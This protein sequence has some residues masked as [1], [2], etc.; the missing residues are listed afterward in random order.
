[1]NITYVSALYDIYNL[2]TVSDRLSND[3]QILLRQ[4]LRL[5]I[6]VDEFYNNILK[7]MEK[8]NTVT[9]IIL[10]INELTIYNM[11]IN[12]KELLSLPPKRT[13][14]KDRCWGLKNVI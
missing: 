11:I 1:M 2:S 5:I 6:F 7:S 12:N 13:P 14:E 3:V 9:I 10:P 4:K 8:S